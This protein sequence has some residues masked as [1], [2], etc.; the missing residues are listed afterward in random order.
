MFFNVKEIWRILSLWRKINYFFNQGI[1]Y[2][3]RLYFS[4][5]SNVSYLTIIFFNFGLMVTLLYMLIVFINISVNNVIYK[6]SYLHLKTQI[7]KFHLLQFMINDSTKKHWIEC[8]FCN[9]RSKKNSWFI[10]FK[11]NLFWFEKYKW[12][13]NR[14]CAI[15]KRVAF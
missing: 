3:K 14:H 15:E 2:L 8:F 5:L 12:N 9:S 1:I 4:T 7:H 13:I 10:L 6:W 11:S